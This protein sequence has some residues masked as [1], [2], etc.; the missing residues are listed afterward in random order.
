MLS[1]INVGAWFQ[2]YELSK[3]VNLLEGESRMVVG[4]V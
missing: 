4:R 3:V 1:E 2:L